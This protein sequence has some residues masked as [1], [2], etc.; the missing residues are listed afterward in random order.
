MVEWE[1]KYG[2]SLPAE[3]RLKYLNMAQKAL[4]SNRKTGLILD[5]ASNVFDA[6]RPTL[7]CALSKLNKYF[8]NE[9]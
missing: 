4:Q 5:E 3:Q 7:F 2:D 1:N 8:L 6:L 9:V